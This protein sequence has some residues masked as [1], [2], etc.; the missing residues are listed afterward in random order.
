LHGLSPLGKT[1]QN[2]QKVQQLSCNPEKIHRNERA[3]E[4]LRILRVQGFDCT[5]INGKR[6]CGVQYKPSASSVISNITAI[7][8]GSC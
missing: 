6:E 5:R 8:D 3:G 2:L 4:N 7:C 1:F